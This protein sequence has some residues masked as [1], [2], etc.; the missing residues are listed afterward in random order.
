M[1]FQQMDI[2]DRF[3]NDAQIVIVGAVFVRFVE[4]YP[5]ERVDLFLL[6]LDLVREGLRHEEHDPLLDLAEGTVVRDLAE[7]V[8]DGDIEVGFFL[9]LSDGGLLFGLAL[10]D[11]TLGETV[12]S[13]VVVFYKQ[14]QVACLGAFVD[15]DRAAA[16]L[17]QT[18]DGCELRVSKNREA[19]FD[20]GLIVDFALGSNDQLLSRALELR[21][22][23]HN[24]EDIVPD[25]LL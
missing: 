24:A 4:V 14:G 3:L 11:M 25:G 16:L 23:D 7:R 9:D 22:S 10:L 19:L 13:A 15:D 8:D 21:D 5:D 6:Y 1:L 12:V 20:I 17:I 2:F 18:A